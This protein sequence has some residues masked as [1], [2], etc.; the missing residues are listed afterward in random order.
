[1]ALRGPALVLLLLFPLLAG[2]LGEEVRVALRVREGETRRLTGTHH[3]DGS[4]V[5]E[6][7][8]TLVLDHADLSL[9]QGIFVKEGA[10]LSTA[11]RVSYMGASTL[12]V[13]DLSGTATL[14]D[15]QM[16]GMGALRAYAGSLLVQG[17]QIQTERVLV[18]GAQVR[19]RDTAW[20]VGPAGM[21]VAAVEVRGGGLTVE[22]GTFAFRGDDGYGVDALGG[23]TAFRNLTLDV[24][25]VGS[26]ALR[27]LG[28][29]LLLAG[30]SLEAVPADDLMLVKHGLARLV[31][32]PL[33]RQARHPLV[34]EARLEIA[35]SLTA[36]VVALPGNVPVEGAD[37]TLRS[38]D[39]PGVEAHAVSDEKGEAR[40]EALQYV[41]DG[42]GSR[43]GN[44]HVLRAAA[45][46]RLGAG[47]A[48]VMEAPATVLVPVAGA[49]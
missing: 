39:A 18:D 41:V 24:G 26:T 9:D 11:S 2:C 25:P 4:I 13:L 1:M 47:P 29:R 42:A 12:H 20:D 16:R 44:P 33:P 27:V 17:G 37:V 32:T 28:G 5:V 35:W 40:F 34:L 7:G 3:L 21:P 45:G 14:V 36:R 19:S 38:A 22:N 23:E 49:G 10:L 15:T 48:F 31:D 30:V 8:G 6:R 46:S 43:P